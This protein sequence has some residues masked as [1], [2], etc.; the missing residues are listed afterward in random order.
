MQG[1][2][3]DIRAVV[4]SSSATILRS[5]VQCLDML[6]CQHSSK[7]SDITQLPKDKWISSPSHLS[8]FLHRIIN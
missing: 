8:S 2:V 3:L 7:A 6:S 4:C 1:K 5:Y